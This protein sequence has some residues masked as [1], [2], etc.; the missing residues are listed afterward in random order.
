M[1]ALKK[2]KSE[3]LNPITKKNIKIAKITLISLAFLLLTA[4]F[5]TGFNKLAKF[6]NENEFVTYQLLTV[7]FHK[8]FEFVKNE[9]MAERRET[10][11]KIE[12]LVPYFT[13]RLEN[14]DPI[15][16]YDDIT[17]SKEEIQ[18]RFGMEF[19]QTVHFNESTNGTNPTPGSLQKYCEDKGLRNE[20]GYNPQEKQCFKTES[21]EVATVIDWAKRKCEGMRLSQ[22]LCYYNE[23][24][25][26]QTGKPNIT[27]HYSKGE[28]SLAN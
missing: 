3:V 21:E 22:C 10:E 18:E 11:K 12:E 1:E 2:E 7:K 26:K 15:F 25:D 27:C 28:L 13:W 24:V 16:S 9:K 20:A 14:P 17:M 8:P 6:L 23:G 4:G 5:Y 19:Y